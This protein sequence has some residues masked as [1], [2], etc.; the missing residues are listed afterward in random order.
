MDI[1]TITVVFAGISVIIAAI[2]SVISSRRANKQRKMQLFTQIYG[3]FLERDFAKDW[4]SITVMANWDD[5]D[6]FQAQNTAQADRE[7][8]IALNHV[9]RLLSYVSVGINRNVIDLDVVDDLIA[10]R[11]IEFWEK[12]S[13]IYYGRRNDLNDPSIGD[14]VEAVYDLLKE[15]HQQQITSVK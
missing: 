2:N 15:K 14:D 6:D 1:Q 4:D 7:R 10:K 8:F 13:Y 5:Y 11:L 9:A 12:Y 3:H